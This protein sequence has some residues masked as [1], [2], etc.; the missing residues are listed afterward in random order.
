MSKSNHHPG[1]HHPGPTPGQ[2][3]VE[4][5]EQYRALLFS[6]AYRML[7]SVSEAEDS[8]QETYLRF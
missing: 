8:V 4:V 7:G 1:R 5:F 3:G 2:G 6:I